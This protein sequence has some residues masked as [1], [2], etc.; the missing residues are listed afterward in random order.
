MPTQLRHDRITLRL[1]DA[2]GVV[3]HPEGWLDC[4]G[5]ATR[6]G[7]FDYGSHRELRPVDEV[8]AAASVASLRGVP[9]TV[10]HPSAGVTSEN[11]KAVTSGW[12]LDAWPDGS[13]LR[14]RV[15]IVD[16][17]AIAAVTEGL[18][19]LSCGYSADV[20][21]VSGTYDGE[22]YDAI[23]R[24]IRYNHLSI[25]EEGRAGPIARLLLDS[26]RNPMIIT[27]AKHN[28]TLAAW[29]PAI[30][31]A[32]RTDEAGVAVTIGED[33]FVLPAG[34]V[35]Q[36]KIMLGI[37]APDPAAAEA[38]MAEAAEEAA[39]VMA[40]DEEGAGA[41]AESAPE[42]AEDGAKYDSARFDA[43]VK[44]AVKRAIAD[45]R[46][47]VAE[48]TR[49]RRYATIAD[50]ATIADALRAACRATGM[51]AKRTDSLASKAD[52][53]SIAEMRG[54]LS[55]IDSQSTSDTRIKIHADKAAEAVPANPIAALEAARIAAHNDRRTAR[56]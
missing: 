40:G 9:L 25:V 31:A 28:A 13:V 10:E 8:M 52:T 39:E 21:P 41:A 38:P 54:W 56:R 51:D 55:A 22:P 11:A 37:S 50:D 49:C 45:E 34:M 26:A 7:V 4:D 33:S 18:R 29:L 53:E 5:I 46:T 12:V 3:R 36:I 30:K 15:R 42:P 19:E 48:V 14:C 24:N 23:Q 1:D 17:Q 6:V 2:A 35:E 43:A 47:R 27:D 20:E 44:A 16:A 32:H